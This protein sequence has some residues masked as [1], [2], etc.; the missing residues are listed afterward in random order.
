[1][2]LNFGIL[3]VIFGCFCVRINVG[4]RIVGVFGFEEIGMS[5]LLLIMVY[6]FVIKVDRILYVKLNDL[7]FKRRVFRIC[8]IDLIMCF[9]MFLKWEVWG[10]LNIYKILFIVR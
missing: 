3:N 5:G 2:V 8:W 9:Y 7:F 4:E 10:G 1:M 6:I